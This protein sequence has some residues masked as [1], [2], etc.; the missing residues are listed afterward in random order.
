M[1]WRRNKKT[2]AE[3]L[4]VGLGNPGEEY[5]QTPHNLGYMTIDRLAE[6][7]GIR[8]ARPE[9]NALVGHGSIGGKS[10]ALAKPLSFMNLSGAPIKRLLRRY[11][12]TLDRL[13]V[14]YDDLD[15]PWETLR[16]KLKGSSAGHNGMKSII[17]SLGSPQFARLRIGIHPGRRL[18]SGADF[19]LRP[20]HR[21][22]LDEAD[23]IINRAAGFVRRLLAEG[24]EKAMADCNRRTRGQQTEEK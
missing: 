5:R 17:G 7:E 24:A 2:G 21:D 4:I 16:I 15:L 6:D 12:L 14:I 19:V 13:L 18:A 22:R 23:A 8:V 3:F 11:D 10:V 9:E 1:F 20:F